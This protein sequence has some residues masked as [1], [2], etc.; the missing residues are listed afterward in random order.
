MKTSIYNQILPF[1]SIMVM[2]VIMVFSTQVVQ[3]SKKQQVD[4]NIK[5]IVFV[6]GEGSHG[7]GAHEHRAGCMLLAKLIQDNTKNITTKVYSEGWPENEDAFEGADAIILFS[8]G[9]PNHMV[10]PHLESLNEYM[11]RGVGL[12]VIHYAV[13]VPAGK[14]GNYFLDW[15]GGFF[16]T[17]W[18]VNPFWTAQFENIPKHDVTKGVNSFE[19]YDEWYYHM[20]FIDDTENIQ[21]VLTALP[22][23]SSLT[24][25]DGPYSNNPH[26]REAVLQRKEP[27]HVMWLYERTK[28]PGRSFGHTGVHY[29]WEWGHPDFR[30]IILNAILW[31]AGA[32]I[33]QGGVSTP[34]ITLEDLEANQDYKQPDDFD[35]NKIK[36]QL[37]EWQAGRITNQANP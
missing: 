31:I 27:Q 14:A 30:T 17:D 28:M 5:K 6:A 21:P 13:V 11:K 34:F 19:I 23:E 33:P 20:R 1:T 26:V 18:S 8:D 16:E 35:R 7:Y 2:G 3:A 25:E 12:G 29:H 9:G 32:E 15:I 4:K 22:P 36:K 10:I 37:E 24:R